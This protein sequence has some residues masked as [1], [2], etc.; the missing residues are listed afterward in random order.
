MISRDFIDFI[1]FLWIS[2]IGWLAGWLDD[3]LVGWLLDR[4]VQELIEGIL[5]RSSSNLEEFGGLVS[6]YPTTT[7]LNFATWMA[8]AVVAGHLVKSV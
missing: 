2:W 6:S 3:W 1:V 5:T 7:T 4:R 8:N